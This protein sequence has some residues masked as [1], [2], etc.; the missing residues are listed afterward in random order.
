MRVNELLQLLADY[1]APC[2]F[3]AILFKIISGP[4]VQCWVA[5]GMS[6]QALLTPE[7]LL[8]AVQAHSASGPMLA[9]EA[10]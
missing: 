5:A 4:G 9:L 7:L 8:R 10:L 1:V 6:P 3:L 2:S